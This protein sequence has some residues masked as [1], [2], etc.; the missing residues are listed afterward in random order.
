MKVYGKNV[1]LEILKENTKVNKI[2]LSNHFNEDE[3]LRLI[4]KKNIPCEVLDPREL[5]KMEKG[6]HQG[7][8]LDVEDVKTYDL[9]DILSYLQGLMIDSSL[10]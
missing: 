4:K 10:F 9:E 3:I 6:L 7:I 1:A 2:Y 8:I 5:D